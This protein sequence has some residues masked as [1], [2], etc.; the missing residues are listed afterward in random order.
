VAC[1]RHNRREKD[2]GV[3]PHSQRIALQHRAGTP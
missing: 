3:Q 1:S 2:L